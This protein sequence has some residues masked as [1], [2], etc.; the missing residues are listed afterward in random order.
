MR[1]VQ[2]KK[3]HILTVASFCSTAPKLF[4]IVSTCPA[5][6]CVC[7]MSNAKYSGEKE[8]WIHLVQ[9]THTFIINFFFTFWPVQ[10]FVQLPPSCS[11]S[12]R[13]SIE[14]KLTLKCTQAYQCRF[15]FN[16]PNVLN[17]SVPVLS[18]QFFM[19]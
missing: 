5:D 13:R 17:D 14:T 1:A 4:L 11:W 9:K 12:C 18:I 3:N 8:R 16:S 2:V 6:F 15:L 10:V 19:L 7:C